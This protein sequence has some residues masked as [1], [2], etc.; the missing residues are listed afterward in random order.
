MAKKEEKTNV[1][2]LLE[3]EKISYAAHEY[4]HADGVIDG[5]G[6][7]NKLGQPVENVFKT[8]VTKGTSGGCFVFCI[9]VAKELDL[10]KAARAAGEKSVTMLHVAD[11]LKTTGY[12]RGGCSPLG[13]KKAFPTVFDI[14][15]ETLERVMVSAGKIGFQIETAPADLVRLAH[16]TTADITAS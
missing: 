6:V 14:S 11:L 10:K 13:M 1:M 5:V 16:G 15:I 4:D 9:P 2:R 8:L 7:A 3:K 12:I